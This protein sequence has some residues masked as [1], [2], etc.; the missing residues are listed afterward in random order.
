MAYIPL[1]AYRTG[2]GIN[3]EPVNAALDSI[4]QQ[5]NQNRVRP[6]AYGST[7]G[8]VPRSAR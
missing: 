8:A 6:K 1:P 5:N 3:L 4:M 2:Q 7:S